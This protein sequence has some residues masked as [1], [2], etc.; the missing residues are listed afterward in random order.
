MKLTEKV[1]FT[2]VAVTTVLAGGLVTARAF[3]KGDPEPKAKIGPLEAMKAAT[4]KVPG[5]AFNANF[6]L[7]EGKWVYGVMV[8]NGKTIKEVLVD[9]ITGKAGAVEAV[10]PEDEAK[11]IKAE[12]TKAIGGVAK[13]TSSR[14]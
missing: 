7:D 12:L 8:I 13:P 14:P 5:R 10:T 9:P 6:E 1:L 4:A 11:E 3:Q 2:T